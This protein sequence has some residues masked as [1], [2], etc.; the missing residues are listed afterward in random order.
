M[1]LVERSATSETAEEPTRIVGIR[2]S[3]DMGAPA[4]LDSFNPKKWERQKDRRGG[5]SVPNG[6]EA[7]WASEP[8]WTLLRIV[9]VSNP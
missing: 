7:S 2:E 5:P 9:K 6:K 1:D 3:V 4:T 8:V